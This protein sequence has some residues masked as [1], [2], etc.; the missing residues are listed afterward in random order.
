MSVDTHPTAHRDDTPEAPAAPDSGPAAGII[1]GSLAAGLATALLLSLVVFPGAT[2]SVITGSILLGFGLGWL[3]LAV[4]AARWAFVPAAGMTTIGLVLI[5][6]APGNDAMTTLNW[7]WPP[8]AVALSVWVFMRIRGS[9][10]RW[11][12][13]PVLGVLALAAVGATAENVAE[14]HDVI[15]A[16]GESYRVN[17]RRLHLDCRGTGGP[18]VVLFNGLG[19]NS[20]S[21][22]RITGPVAGTARVCAYDR[23]GQGRS[24]EA[25]HPQDGVAA[26]ADL[27]DLLAAAHLTGPYVLAGHST[28]GTYAMTYAARYPDQVAGMVLLDSSSPE[29]LT[30]MPAYAGQYAVMRRGFALLPTIS[31]LGLGRMLSGAT[32]HAARNMRDELSVALDVF[33]QAQ[34]LTTLDG[35]PLAVLTASDSLGDA[36]WAGAQ[37]QLARLSTDVVHRTV[38][39]THAGLL[40]DESPAAD[41]ARAITEVIRAVRYRS[42]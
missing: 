15:G 40:A 34:A 22:D 16:P 35:R 1:A 41:S 4:R 18:T 38:N 29:Q 6:V 5:A 2:E 26:A 36:G 3:L 28:G 25:A 21:W 9:R 13:I 7:V 11:L 33:T 12:V 10:G 37:D 30:R 39:S 27:H 19:E 24:E 20:A 8:A 23:A 32:P 31:R 14:H 42:A 17:G